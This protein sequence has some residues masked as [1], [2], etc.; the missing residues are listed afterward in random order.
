[1]LAMTELFRVEP[2]TPLA[3]SRGDAAVCIPVYGAAF[4][5][6]RCLESVLEHTPKEVAVLVADDCTPEADIARLVADL[7][8]RFNRDVHLLR[9]PRNLGFVANVNSC[10]DMTAPADVVI[11]N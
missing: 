2:G 5:F 3:L 8:R 1:M 9:Q 7:V 4:L 10:F 6:A 11:L